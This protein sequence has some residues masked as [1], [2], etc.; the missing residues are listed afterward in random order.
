ML[1]RVLRLEQLFPIFIIQTLILTSCNYADLNWDN[2]AIMYDHSI[3][4]SFYLDNRVYAAGGVKSTI[5]DLSR[6]P[7]C[8]MK[9]GNFNNHQ[10]LKESSI[11][12]I[13]EIQNQA[14]GRCLVWEA[15]MGDWYGHSG[16]LLLGTATTLL[17]Q[18]K[19]NTALIIF[20]NT[21]S[22][23]VH[24]GGDIFWLIKQ[25]TNAYFN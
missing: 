15:Y 17:I 11:V 14:S 7:I 3:H 19:S 5:Q 8:Y 16:L 21:N 20:T 10:I 4:P 6:F 13:F 9:G 23:L 18:P 1:N 25:K 12:K 24:P 2:I 22:G